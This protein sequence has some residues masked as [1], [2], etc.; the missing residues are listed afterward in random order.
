[1]RLLARRLGDDGP[2]VVE[3]LAAAQVG[4]VERL[5][6]LQQVHVATTVVS[7]SFWGVARACWTC[8]QRQGGDSGPGGR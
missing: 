6:K 4:L 8:Q 2:D 7:A 3:R 5:A 1:M